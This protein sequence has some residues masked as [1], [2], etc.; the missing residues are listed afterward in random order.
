MR[1]YLGRL[2]ER[3]LG[4]S[5]VVTIGSMAELRQREGELRG[6]RLVLFDLDLGD[7]STV[8]WAIGWAAKETNTRLVALSSVQGAVPFKQ[9]QVAGISL[10]HKNDTQAELVAALRV[11]LGGGVVVSRQVQELLAQSRRDPLSPVKVL[12]PKELRVLALL[13]QRLRNEEI[14]EILGCSIATVA[15]HRKHI[16]AK[17]DCHHI[18][19]VIDFAIRHGVV[20]SVTVAEPPGERGVK[21][22]R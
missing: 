6:A 21:S 4:A 2:L 16:M 17:L 15:D 9:L 8:E 18:E 22:P 14:A 20:H 13:G 19:E 12:G 3:E 7:G 1:D 10:V 11:V 5:A